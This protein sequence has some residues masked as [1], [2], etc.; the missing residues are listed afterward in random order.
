MDTI[1]AGR[2]IPYADRVRYGYE[3]AQV[4]RRCAAVADDLMLEDRYAE[5]WRRAAERDRGRKPLKSAPDD[6]DV[7]GEVARDRRA[8]CVR[9]VLGEPERRR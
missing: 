9:P 3:S 8:R 5:R 7:D 1:R 6:R 4:A 2:Q